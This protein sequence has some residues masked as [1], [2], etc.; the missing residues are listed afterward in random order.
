MSRPRHPNKNIESALQYAEQAGWTVQK[1][2]GGR[3]HIWGK[4]MCPERSRDG[5]IEFIHCT[6]SNPEQHAR[7]IRRAI[8]LC[9][10]LVQEDDANA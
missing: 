2:E 6:P 4:A 10:H 9:P 5:D 8:D 7:K 3:A 1:A